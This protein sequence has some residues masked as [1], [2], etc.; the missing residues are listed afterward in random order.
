MSTWSVLAVERLGAPS[1]LWPS[2]YGPAAGVDPITANGL[3]SIDL[4]PRLSPLGDLTQQIEQA[5]SQG[6]YSS[7][8][9]DLRDPDGTLADA[10]GPFGAT[11]ATPTRYFGPWVQV[12]ENWGESN[13]ALRYLGYLDASSLQWLEDDAVTQA[14]VNHASQLIQERLIT[15]YPELLRPWPR[16]PTN[17]TQD[18]MQSTADAL[19]DAA[20]ADFT[21]RAT[22]TAIEAGLWAVG[23]LSWMAG[24]YLA[25]HWIYSKPPD[26]LTHTV[27]YSS[28]PGS[29]EPPS[30]RITIGGTSY[31]VDHLAWDE[32]ITGVIP[33]GEFDPAN[34]REQLVSI[35][36]YR[37][38]RI[39]LAGAPDLS[40][41]LTLGTVVAWDL[42]ESKRTHYLLAG[43]ADGIAAPV[44]GSDGQQ[45]VALNTVDQLAP[46]EVLTLT[47]MDSTSGSARTSTADLPK[48]IDFD[49]ETGKVFLAKPLDQG[50][51]NVSKVRRNSQDPT[52][53]DGLAYARAVIAPWTLDVS[54]FVPA[55][56]DTPVFVWMPYDV[57]TPHLY[58]AVNIQVLDQE[59]RLVI[60]RRGPEAGSGQFPTSGLWSG[61]WGGTW[62]W[63][64]LPTPQATHEVYGNVLQWPGGA[65]AFAGPVIYIE[66]DLSGG[67]PTPVNG[68]RPSW[69]SWKSPEVLTQDLDSSWN[70]TGVQW[71]PVV[72]SGDIPGRLVA[73][74]SSTPSPGSYTRTSSGDWTFRA[75]NGNGSLAAA[76]TPT[77]SGTLPAGNWLALGMGIWANAGEQE[78]LQ[79][80][81]VTGA[82]FPFTAVSAV[83]LSQAAGGN[84]TSRQV[85]QLWAS[86]DAIPAGPWAL[87]G[88]LIV[89][90]YTQEIEGLVYPRTV[91]H[92][93]T[94]AG[95]VSVDHKTLEILPSTLQPLL[96]GGAPG[97]RTIQGW[98]GLALETFADDSFAASRRLRFIHLDENLQ[99]VN[100][101]PEPDPSLPTDPAASFRRGDIVASAV[102]PGALI[103]RM[104]R[105]SQTEDTM[106]GL[107]GGRLFCVQHTLP[108]TVER[109]QLQATP[110]KGKASGVAYSGD[111]MT[112]SEYLEAWAA[113]QLAT[114]VPT[115]TGNLALVS[116]SA[117]RLQV[118]S[119]NG[120]RVS[121]QASE[122]SKRARTVAWEG[123]L[124][125]VRVSY[126]D[127]LSDETLSVEVT[128]AFDGGR[129]VEEDH[130]KILSGPTMALALGKAFVYWYGQPVPILNETWV[131][132]T[133]GVAG[134]LAPV[135]WSG[136]NVG[137]RI[138]FTPYNPSNPGPITTHKIFSMSPQ[139]EERSCDVELRQQPRPIT[140]EAE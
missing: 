61:S 30:S 84:L 116:R 12:W 125:K 11:M 121:V 36:T 20:V 90:S 102:A 79:G 55:A 110:P 6:A 48:A 94:G 54:E 136:W 73:F 35:Y 13:A 91:L 33:Y 86:T 38:V 92:K 138:T 97:A 49:G 23:Q 56:T 60:T 133:Y 134:E 104:V 95:L 9:L 117:G 131:D 77:V 124:R 74:C 1:P 98:Y 26:A 28:Q 39:Y 128:A 71:G 140:P 59:G 108:V 130:S 22:A 129:I 17:A 112:A 57:A 105:T 65:N 53:F 66:G 18:W 111:G 41:V 4:T 115:A 64:G 32:S 52:L 58:G 139:L 132:R 118:R 45:H 88:G 40:A 25:E 34:P 46:G 44:D 82:A 127:I 70:G 96:L 83:L 29:L 63:L 21:P 107:I 5:S 7:I 135:F 93:M 50:Y 81:V 100:G 76:T 24:T 106:A 16:V 80:L 72:A 2:V 42:P 19:L 10:L 89:Q 123:Y 109:L 15:D 114:F 3:A 126:M 68:W 43:G 137:D 14:T 99:I 103:A 69:R 119:I 37:P 120:A 87:G 27:D 31:L 78:A 113:S 75:H 51:F 8:D 101:D 122:R 85:H 62:S 47:F 67:E